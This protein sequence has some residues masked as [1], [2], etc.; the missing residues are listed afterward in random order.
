[1]FESSSGEDLY[2][3]ENMHSICRLEDKLIRDYKPSLYTSG[4]ICRQLSLPFYITLMSGKQT[5]YEI[6][7][8]DMVK[9][10]QSLL[11]CWKEFANNKTTKQNST[12]DRENA[13]VKYNAMHNVYY[14]LTDT[15]FISSTKPVVGKLRLRFTNNEL[16]KLLSTIYRGYGN[17][18]YVILG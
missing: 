4:I 18:L 15:G 5:C 16:R 7:E 9:F 12:I 10:K 2:T 3:A 8:S 13:C 14:F 11:K 1:M 17:I 6:T